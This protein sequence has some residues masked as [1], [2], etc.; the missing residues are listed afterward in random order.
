WW[1]PTLVLPS[2]FIRAFSWGWRV[3][4]RCA[5]RVREPSKTLFPQSHSNQ[6]VGSVS[7]GRFESAGRATD[8][9]SSKQ[10]R[11]SLRKFLGAYCGKCRVGA[12]GFEPATPAV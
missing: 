8:A 5:F 10:E 1:V 4:F 9:G 3:I 2:M 7:P 6:A 11:H 12:A